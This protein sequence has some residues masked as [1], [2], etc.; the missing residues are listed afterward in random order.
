[1]VEIKCGFNDTPD[2]K[3]CELLV[4]YGPTLSVDIGFDPNHDPTANPRGIP[5]PRIRNVHALVDSGA[6]ECCI[7]SLLATQLNLPLVNRRQISGAH[8][9]KETNVYLAQVHIPALAITMN[10]AF[11]G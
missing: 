2:N 8:G 11:C 10:G 5:V 7:D 1:M 9:Q 3:G 4:A 6:T